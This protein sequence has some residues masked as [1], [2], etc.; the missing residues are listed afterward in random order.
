MSLLLL[1]LRRRRKHRNGL[2]AQQSRREGVYNR[3][4]DLCVTCFGEEERRR[5]RK[6]DFQKKSRRER[7]IVRDD[8]ARCK[9]FGFVSLRQSLLRKQVLFYVPFALTSKRWTTVRI[10]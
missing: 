2:V 10:P 3:T 7:Y 8:E 4:G 9:G 6:T 1:I 5:E